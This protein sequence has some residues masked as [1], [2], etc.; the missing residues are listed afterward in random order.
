MDK[1][2]LF[3]GIDLHKR[4]CFITVVNNLGEIMLQM[5]V[6][7]S[8]EALRG[9]FAQFPTLP[10]T[11][12]EAT[13]NWY[14]IADLLEEMGIDVSLAHPKK[15]KD[16]Y[17]A[18]KT[19]KY[20]SQWLAQLLRTD[21]IPVSY[22]LSSSLRSLRDLLRTRL[23]LVQVRTGLVNSSRSTLAK[24][25]LDFT[26]SGKLYGEEGLSFLR[27]D[28]LPLDYLNKLTLGS[29]AD[30]VELL[31]S[32]INL[33]EKEIKSQIKT[34]EEIKLL[35]TIR[36]IGVILASTIR[37]EVGDIER[38]PTEKAFASNCRLAPG[39]HSSG[40]RS[41]TTKTPKDGNRYLKWAFSE[42][43]H[44]LTRWDQDANRHYNRLLR[45]KPKHTALSIMARSLARIA[46][47]VLKN[48]DVYRGFKNPNPKK[49]LASGTLG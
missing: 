3:A 33:L 1:A 47:Y 49:D 32:K 18:K 27:S 15:L 5:K 39:V 30:V 40:G 10:K 9:F 8:N 2:T 46:Y 44:P 11:V 4:Y 43:I 42:G 21:M 12:I 20:D 26:G 48:K 35:M 6:P 19:D 45:K 25:N 24:Y 34:D 23:G 13:G 16:L 31:N 17:G 37:Y 36:G 38:F 41:R 28:E 22:K 29:K 7:N 14:W